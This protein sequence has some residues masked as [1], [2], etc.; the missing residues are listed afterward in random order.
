MRLVGWKNIATGEVKGCEG[1]PL[2]FS[3]IHML[4]PSLFPLIKSWPER[5]PIM[6]FYLNVCGDHLIQGF[7]PHGLQLMDV[8]KLDTLQ[9]AETFINQL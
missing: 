5:F 1:H 6:D 8:G 4:Y 2:A 9:E 7:E 3:G